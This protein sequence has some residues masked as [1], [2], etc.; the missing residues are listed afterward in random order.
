MNIHKKKNISVSD[1]SSNLSDI[2]RVQCEQVD[3][4]VQVTMEKWI[5][6]R[7]G[8]IVTHN[9]QYHIIQ[10]T[11]C[12]MLFSRIFFSRDNNLIQQ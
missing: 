12:L 7:K 3:K 2:F 10:N 5:I 6:E 4:L 8:K 1:F 9:G 11:F